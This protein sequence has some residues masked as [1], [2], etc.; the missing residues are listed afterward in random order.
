MALYDGPDASSPELGRFCGH[1]IPE[2]IHSSGNI[3]TIVFNPQDYFEGRFSLYWDAVSTRPPTTS[4]DVAID[5]STCLH[6][7]ELSPSSSLIVTSPGYPFGYAGNINCTWLV[8]T[9]PGHHMSVDVL[10]INIEGRNDTCRY[11]TLKFFERPPSHSVSAWHL[12][13]T[14]CGRYGGNQI[15]IF[16]TEARIEFFTDNY[17]NGTGF[18]ISLSSVCGG[19]IPI[20]AGG[21]ITLDTSHVHGAVE[22]VWTLVARPGRTIQ[23]SLED[24]NIQSTGATCGDA[25]LEL[26][27]GGSAESPFLDQGR[28]CGI[29]LAPI[30]ETSSNQIRVKFAAPLT[31]ST[32][33]RL[34]IEEKSVGCGGVVT[35]S[36]TSRSFDLKSPGYPNIPPHDVECDWTI[37]GPVHTQLRIDFDIHSG[38]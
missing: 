1:V 20:P 19:T 27:N 30:S 23:A 34:K 12:N 32:R 25:Y 33:F 31:L 10:D 7:V 36:D 3:I 16:S 17:V 11:D 9:E 35:L 26:R 4:T 14:L 6:R 24:L 37:T 22:C 18:K 2:P 28:Y 13:T 15:D 8:T 38:T 29:R 5:N 21:S